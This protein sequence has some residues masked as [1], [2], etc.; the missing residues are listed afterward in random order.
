MLG[1]AFLQQMVDNYDGSYIMAAA[2]YNA[3][4][5][6]VRQ[7][8]ALFGDPRKPDVDPVDW[9]ER[10]PFTETRDYVHK[11]TESIAIYRARF[12]ASTPETHI[13]ADIGRGRP[14]GGV[15]WMRASSL[16]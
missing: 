1:T 2:A 14:G 3:G 12:G 8:V 4:P 13:A 7:W 16:Q 15:A 11:V 9:I 6:R 10:I 5:G